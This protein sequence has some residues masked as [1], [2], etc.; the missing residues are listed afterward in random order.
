VPPR[1]IQL[2]LLTLGTLSCAHK[3]GGP[4]PAPLLPAKVPSPTIT[5]CAHKPPIDTTLHQA[6]DVE[7]MPIRRTSPPMVY[8]PEDRQARVQGVVMVSGIIDGRGRIEVR[9][10]HIVESVSPGLDREAIQV[11]S[12]STFWPGCIAGNP[13]RARVQLPVAFSLR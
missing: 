9:S 4:S 8:P 2:L 7:E 12:Q 5:S 3:P 10:I 6:D 11:L 13:V 1:Q